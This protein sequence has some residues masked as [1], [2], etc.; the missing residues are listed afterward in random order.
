MKNFALKLFCLGLFLTL[1][2]VENFSQTPI[3]IPVKDL[4][5]FVSEFNPPYSTMTV[6]V[7]KNLFDITETVTITIDN[8]TKIKNHKG[9]PFADVGDLVIGSKVKIE[10]GR[11]YS[12]ITA[13]TI[14]TTE[15]LNDQKV[16]GYFERLDKNGSEETAWISGQAVR[17][18]PGAKIKGEDGWDKMTFNSFNEM[19]LGS[20]VTVKGKR[21]RKGIFLVREGEAKPNM[22]SKADLKL[23]ER[24]K[25]ESASIFNGSN[26]LTNKF[27]IEKYGKWTGTDEDLGREIIAINS[28]STG[29]MK[30]II[31]NREVIIKS[32]P[33]YID[34][35]GQKLVP[36]YMREV[37]DTD[38]A[39][40]NFRFFVKA[41]DSFNA[42]ALPD[43]T[44]VVHT[45]LLKM[46]KN[47]SQLA[48]VLGHEIAHVTHEHA[49]RN[50]KAGG[51][52]GIIAVGSCWVMPETCNITKFVT[53]LFLL[54]LS[55]DFEDEADRVGLFYLANS[56][57][58]L[59]EAPRVWQQVVSKQGKENGVKNF[60]YSGHSTPQARLTNLNREISRNYRDY[61]FSTTD[62][63]ESPY[64]A[65]IGFNF[66]WLK[67]IQE[68]E[69]KA[70]I[71][72]EQKIKQEET[73]TAPLPPRGN[74]PTNKENGKK[75]GK[76]GK[77]GKT[78][79]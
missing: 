78:R 34:E 5:G 41:D 13:K 29:G 14:K 47:E 31:N 8:K 9:D 62:K 52:G 2:A 51:I 42:F 17:F 69:D 33:E 56:G 79:P 76:G 64:M 66:G 23:R 37:P 50:M 58:D 73:T 3:A 45:G 63:G 65:N 68:E 67:L 39:K 77:G 40:I 36:K 55:R 48:A 15:D 70:K 11:I 59:R 27:T 57:Y 44:I 10:G 19:M 71:A 26:F 74:P 60:L 32:L 4:E 28:K 12:N 30:V 7:G 24:V 16:T 53:G 21:D 20:Q 38:P 1:F 72:A 35:V 49:R 6:D 54:E 43:G 22:F 61:D 75:G 18:S 46:L 25:K